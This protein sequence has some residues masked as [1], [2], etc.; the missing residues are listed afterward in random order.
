MVRLLKDTENEEKPAWEI[1]QQQKVKSVLENHREKDET[2]NWQ[3]TQQH[4]INQCLETKDYEDWEEIQENKI[5]QCMEEQFKAEKEQGKSEEELLKSS[6][7]EVIQHKEPEA[8]TTDTTEKVVADTYDLGIGR[9]R[10]VKE[11]P[12]TLE[13]EV[14]SQV[15]V[16]GILTDP[17]YDKDGFSETWDESNANMFFR[18]QR[19]IEKEMEEQNF[20]PN[21]DPQQ[22]IEEDTTEN[23][24]E[25]PIVVCQASCSHHTIQVDT[26]S[27]QEDNKIRR[28]QDIARREQHN[29]PVNIDLEKPIGWSN[30]GNIKEERK[31]VR[32]YQQGECPYMK[33][34]LLGHEFTG[35]MDSG[36]D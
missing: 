7:P 5:R 14:L 16:M 21:L 12:I 33:I 15:K 24:T 36:E 18:F 27:L 31:R 25:K 8:P 2:P 9:V 30:Y 23:K 1:K 29:G 10:P 6:D 3:K 28:V 35:L 22:I 26:N 34:T 13:P 20:D 17:K 4:K 19:Q 11:S 32:L